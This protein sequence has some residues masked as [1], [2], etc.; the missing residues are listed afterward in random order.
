[1]GVRIRDTKAETAIA[2]VTVME[3]SRNNRPTMPPMSK[4]GMNTATSDRLIDST[5]KPISREPCSAAS[6]GFMPSSMCR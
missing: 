6:S 2:A 5:V 3:N 1:M 4:S